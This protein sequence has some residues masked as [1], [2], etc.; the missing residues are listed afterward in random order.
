MPSSRTIHVAAMKKQVLVFV[1][2]HEFSSP[3]ADDAMYL[4]YLMLQIDDVVLRHR[5]CACRFF[6]FYVF[7][8]V[9]FFFFGC[10]LQNKS[11]GNKNVAVL[12]LLLILV[13]LIATFGKLMV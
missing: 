12:L 4:W 5:T 6:F 3:N 2:S 1:S 10:S 8:L 13:Q 11:I 9:F 7:P